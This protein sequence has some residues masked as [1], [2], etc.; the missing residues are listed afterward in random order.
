MSLGHANYTAI[1][2]YLVA[3]NSMLAM[4]NARAGLRETGGNVVLP[5]GHGISLL[6]RVKFRINVPRSRV[7]AP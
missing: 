4:L 7:E 1:A 3:L 6:Q 5:Q 2:E